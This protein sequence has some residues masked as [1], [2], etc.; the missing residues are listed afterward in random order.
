[1]WKPKEEDEAENK[2]Q[3]KIKIGEIW[4][5]NGRAIWDY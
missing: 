3:I 2:I 1:M 4:M 5:S